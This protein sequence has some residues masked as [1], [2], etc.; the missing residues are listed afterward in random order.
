[1]QGKGFVI[2]FAILLGVLSI[3][4]LSY[5]WFANK[6]RNQASEIAKNNP[7]KEKEVLD[8]LAKADTLKILGMTYEE[9]QNKEMNL[10]LDLKGGMNVL[11]QIN[12]KDLL[13]NYTDYTANQFFQDVL[14]A[15][16]LKQ[17]NG[18]KDYIDDFFDAYYEQEKELGIKVPLAS[19]DIFGNKSLS[20][21]INFNSTNEEVE[22]VIRKKTEASV[23]T[24]YEV[25]RARIDQFGVT[26]PN[27]QRVENS[28]RILV[29]LP[30]I[31]DTER[32]K[33]L[34]QSSAKLE[35]WEVARVRD[36]QNYFSA[37][38]AKAGIITKQN[39][40]VNSF[41]SK[42][43]SK[44]MNGAEVSVVNLTDTAYVNKLLHSK[45]AIAMK[46]N[47]L[48]YVDFYWAAKP[49]NDKTLDLYAIKNNIKQ[50]APL[51]GDNVSGANTSFD[52]LNRPVIN[53]Q[54]SPEGAV[55]W[56]NVTE[57]NLGL[58]VAVVLDKLVYTAPTVNT[59]IP[60]GQSQISG[61]YTV[62]EATDL[63]N[64]LGAGKLPASAKIIQAEVVGPSLGKESIQQGVI[65]F[66]IALAL[67]L[68]Y[69]IFYY[70]TAGLY[71]NLA[72]L[73]NLLFIFG[74]LASFR[75]VLTLPGIAGIVLTI[76]MSVDAN[77]IIFERIKEELRLGKKLAQAT[78][79]GFKHAL[80][81]I[82]DGN[83]TI[84]L[85]AGV[86]FFFGEGPVKGF[87]TTL[88]VGIITSVFSAVLLSRYFMEKTISKGKN[89]SFSTA[90]TKNWLHNLQI[91]FIGKR[92]VFYV[93]SALLVL[94]SLGSLA[95]NKLN[96]GTDFKGGRSYVV[97][98]EKP[99]DTE[100]L[101]AKLSMLF[102]DENGNKEVTQVKTFG[103]NNQVKISTKYKIDDESTNVENEIETKIFEAIKEY[104]PANITKEQFSSPEDKSEIGV[105]SSVKVG[106]TVAD[107]ITIGAFIAVGLSLLIVFLYL[108]YSFKRWQYSLGAVLAVTHDVLIVL[109]VFSL[110]YTI[111]PFS[112]EI[113]QAFIA[114]ILT[115]IGYSI[116][117]T[118]IVFDR[119]R[120]NTNNPIKNDSRSFGQLVN[121]SINSTLGR[122]LN[123]SL[124]TLFVIIV[125]FLFGGENIRGFMFALLV[126]IGVGT[127]S[128]IFIASFIMYDLVNKT[129]KEDEKK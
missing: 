39:S 88:M 106:P 40:P 65:S 18:N 42:V 48:K 33:K 26:Q 128:S 96:L 82:I 78:A 84:F 70:S 51:D 30:G 97:R 122:T 121:Y 129:K 72:L 2:I 67:V 12:E 68:L 64:V 11:L 91:D 101:S 93:L 27:V 13:L 81:S 127:Y 118:V 4:Q 19:A 35:F 34:L 52:E 83:I 62:E 22:K 31:K 116:N 63:V 76:A 5:T 79:D 47:N 104:L 15:A 25:I 53:M 36:I 16:D 50:K 10:G 1:M 111:L 94:I 37:I 59:V 107:D 49:N 71:A 86:L 100:L 57:K 85:T 114:A 60:T 89:I 66:A 74:I 38:D 105:M 87:A 21:E 7:I 112:L 6:V 61:N 58:P 99:I 41:L 45:E 90:I 73:L 119:I 9:A 23:N 115:V 32:V 69:M 8:S 77:V 113:D 110:F 98:A 109:G 20:S 108:V 103:S 92:K 117:D 56:K 44:P 3:N 80:S 75:A 28:G 43:F 126:G 102:T 14:K 55:I 29:E 124:I 95:T 125:I 120:E 123:T 46:Q 54:M 24:A 17:K